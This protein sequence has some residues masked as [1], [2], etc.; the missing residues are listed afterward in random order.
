M[1]AGWHPSLPLVY[2]VKSLG[3]IDDI[4]GSA[5]TGAGARGGTPTRHSLL[6]LVC[7]LCLTWWSAAAAVEPP[8]IANY[9]ITASL[10]VSQHTV[11][12]HEVLTWHNAG[13]EDAS[14]LYFHLYLN[15][16]ANNHSS[17][18]REAGETVRDWQRAKPNGWGSLE[19]SQLTVDGNDRTTAIAYVHPDDDNVEDRTVIRVPLDQPVAAGATARI[20]IAF[21]AKLPKVMARAGY[22]GPFHLVAQW[23]PK[24]GVFQHGTWNCHQ[25]HLT[26]EFFA[27]FGIYDV[28]LTVPRDDV[29][30]STGTVDDERDNG[31]G[32]KTVHVRAEDVHDFAWTVDPRFVEAT[33]VVDGVALRALMQPRH[34]DQASR[35]LGAAT[36][37][38]R[39]YRD[40]FGAYP[41]P[42]LTIVD[43]GPGAIA[44]GGMEYP[45]L[46]TAGTAWWMPAGLRLPEIV[47]VHEFGHQYWYG[48]VANNEFEAAWLDEGINSYVEGLVMDEVYG[49]HGSYLHLFGLD[50]D[51]LAAHRLSYLAAPQHDPLT[52]FAWQFLDR[53][54]Y[55][56]VTYAKT[57]LVLATLERHLGPE[58]MRAALRAY[59]ERWRF[60]HPSDR[61][62]VEAVNQ[63]AGE[64]L[65]WYFDQTIYGTGV[66]DY[67][68]TRV[69]SE[70]ALE[71][72][73]ARVPPTPTESSPTAAK[74]HRYRNEVVVERL[75]TI[76]M[77]V[78]IAIG[79]EDGTETAESWDGQDR[80]RRF[81]YTGPLRVEYAT[82]DPHRKLPLDVN[83]LNNSRMRVSGTRGVI[84]L[85]GRSGFWFQNLLHFLTGL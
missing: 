32:T 83:L 37:A 77:P 42:Q 31:D 27:D 46:I 49:P 20:E 28:R 34:L 69:R 47:T 79:F 65:S 57:A 43:P 75:G 70:D 7:G 8:H 64:D 59:F 2:K 6:W 82:V 51:A 30:G 26:T 54:S 18:M 38:L 16:F 39:R 5:A 14:D 24:L 55:A 41:Y 74:D 62:F 76:R 85:A 84:R 13:T 50:A 11:T 63:S 25:Y 40:W 19:I 52:R 81:E 12:G 53:R 36:A 72:A 35:Y 3:A 45:T 66:L 1:G 22:A 29:F 21:T 17:F 58:R 68:V 10:D 67:A 80:W 23:F 15:A 44:A 48:I 71:F 56:S 61:D 60:G 4:A 73:G 33:E 78:E 9:D